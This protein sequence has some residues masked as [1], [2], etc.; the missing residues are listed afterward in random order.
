MIIEALTHLFTPAPTY[1]KKMGYLKESIAIEARVNRCRDA[2]QPHL[3]TCKKL[4][5]QQAE[6][7]EQGSNIM[8]LGSG[9]FHDIPMSE[10]L[11]L[12]HTI[13]AVDI[14]HLQK[15]KNRYPDINFVEHDVTGLNQKL[16]D[17]VNNNKSVSPA[18]D[19][20][21]IKTP[22]LIISLN[23][24]SQLPLK[25]IRYA[26]KHSHDLGILFQENV[27]QAHVDWLKKQKTNV[28]LISDIEREYYH[29]EKLVE[30]I[31]TLLK[32]DLP[33]PISTWKWNIAPEGEADPEIS[34]THLVGYWTL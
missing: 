6:K 9:G 20:E 29:H 27:M 16:F 33:D 21:L 19:W 14:V 31:P 8:I 7:L 30:T 18:S 4:I 11:A 12:G 24:L 32:I 26:E 28:L 22:D 17:A 25:M 13:T 34:I 1:V 15:V 5:L 10:L 2:W 23:L 3:D